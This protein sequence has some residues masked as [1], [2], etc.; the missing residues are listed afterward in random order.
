MCLLFQVEKMNENFIRSKA[1]LKECPACF[2]NFV[3]PFCDITCSPKQAKFVKV[4][5]YGNDTNSKP[6]VKSVD[7][8]ITE[9]YINSTFESCSGVNF[10]ILVL[11]QIYDQYC[12]FFKNIFSIAFKPQTYSL[13]QISFLGSLAVGF[14]S[15]IGRCETAKQFYR[16]IGYGERTEVPFQMNYITEPIPGLVPF[17]RTTKG[18]D[19]VVNVSHF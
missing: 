4:N 17:N 6:Y 16:G 19:E 7:V 10:T 1:L 8:S 15:G 18:C 13:G 12:D 9:E 5:Q 14:M 2:Y 3:Q 11:F